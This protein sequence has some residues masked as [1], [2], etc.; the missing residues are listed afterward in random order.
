MT[1]E[2]AWTTGIIGALIL[3]IVC[4][5]TT[6]C[7]KPKEENVEPIPSTT[8]SKTEYD[9]GWLATVEHDG[10]LFIVEG[11]WQK[12]AIIHHPDCPCLKKQTTEGN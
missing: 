4:L 10:H 6:G 11:G 9:Y 7:S 12:G 2:Q 1:I 8:I 3:I 5:L